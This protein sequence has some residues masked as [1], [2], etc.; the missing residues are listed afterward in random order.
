MRTMRGRMVAIALLMPLAAACSSGSDG[1]ARTSTTGTTTASA[2]ETSA[3]TEP[4]STASVY[5]P[6]ALPESVV[7]TIDM[8][9]GPMTP[10]VGFGSVWVSNHHADEVSRIDPATNGVIA[11][12]PTGVQPGQMLV[13]DDVVWVADYGE[14][15]LTRID[16][17]D[18]TSTV[19]P[20][21]DTAACGAPAEAGGLIWI[22]NCDVGVLTGIDPRTNEV[23]RSIE[24]GA[25]FSFSADGELWLGTDEA[26]LRIDPDSGKTLQTIALGC[27]TA[28]GPYSFSGDRMFVAYRDGDACQDGHVAVVDRS[29]G[30][31]LERLDVGRVPEAPIVDGGTVYVSNSFDDTISVID[32]R[33]SELVDEI[34]AP[35]VSEDAFAIG[36]DAI[37]VPDFELANLY[38]VDPAA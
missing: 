27:A 15:S 37:W 3:A 32:A 23:M 18:D 4:T 25:G 17:D 16:P 21:G 2:T 12:I 9:D 11:E 33:R 35:P 5:A 6:N 10:I 30:K 1:G 31:V 22:D 29:S 8:A 26:V 14:A 24:P 38:R 28:A 7:A 36:F 34:A 13:T 20:A 19:V